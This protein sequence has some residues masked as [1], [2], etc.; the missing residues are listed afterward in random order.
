MGYLLRYRADR[1]IPVILPCWCSRAYL[2]PWLL[3]FPGH[4]CRRGIPTASSSSSACCWFWG[5]RWSRLFQPRL[6]GR[7]ACRLRILWWVSARNCSDWAA[8]WILCSSYSGLLCWTCGRLS[9]LSILR[10]RR[11]RYCRSCSSQSSWRFFHCQLSA[12]S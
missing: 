2:S 9:S 8:A 10:T 1:N 3:I 12:P 7:L 11:K 4:S 5:T 6:A